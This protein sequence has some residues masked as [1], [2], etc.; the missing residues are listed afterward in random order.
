MAPDLRRWEARSE[1]VE[2]RGRGKGEERRRGEGEE[3]RGEEKGRREG[4]EGKG[5][6][7]KVRM[8]IRYVHFDHD[9]LN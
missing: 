2:R 5:K 6:R 9:S 1:G 7:E 8:I 3:R 4:G